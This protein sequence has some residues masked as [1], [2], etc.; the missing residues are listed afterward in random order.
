MNFDSDSDTDPDYSESLSEVVSKARIANKDVFAA[1]KD[2]HRSRRQAII[3]EI[4]EKKDE[5]NKSKSVW[6]EDDQGPMPS[7]GIK[8]VKD[9]LGL[10]L[11]LLELDAEALEINSTIMKST[12][13]EEPVK[14]KE[15]L[16]E[17]CEEG[18]KALRNEIGYWEEPGQHALV[19]EFVE[20]V[21]DVERAIKDKLSEDQSQ[22]KGEA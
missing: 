14:Y 13:A 5:Y 1:L 6:E 17:M 4:D 8:V 3:D 7:G 10:R 20:K 12:Q 19:E 21:D 22:A 11:K 2:A 18:A 15:E 9:Y 16:K